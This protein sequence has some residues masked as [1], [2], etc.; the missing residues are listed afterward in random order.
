[1]HALLSSDRFRASW[2]RLD[3]SEHPDRMAALEGVRRILAKE[4]VSLQ[5]V[6][7]HAIAGALAAEKKPATSG[8]AFA[9][10]FDGMFS[11]AF[12]PRPT[13]ASAPAQPAAPRPA[14]KRIVQDKDVP[15]HIVGI[16]RIHEIR[17]T[18]TGRMAVVGIEDGGSIYDPLVA[19]DDATI[20]MLES[21]AL[22]KAAVRATIAPPQKDR[23]NPR[24]T[25]L[26][27]MR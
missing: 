19:F 22:H 10:I 2:S 14:R 16:V 24:I 13:A 4:G 6:L 7:E 20:E 17:P 18:R 9:D 27:I 15:A 8:S 21:A 11:D 5:T 23:Q 1:M 26:S 25:R 3:A 12:G